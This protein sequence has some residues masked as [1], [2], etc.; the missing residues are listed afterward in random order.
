MR[1]GQ[2]LHPATTR[3]QYN[4]YAAQRKRKERSERKYIKS[5]K[6]PQK[7]SGRRRRKKYS[8][9]SEFIDM[10]IRLAKYLYRLFAK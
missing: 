1:K 8:A 4:T 10:L 6:R 9:F 5:Q 2:R 7:F 3:G